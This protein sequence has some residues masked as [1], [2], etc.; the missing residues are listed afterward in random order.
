[1]NRC[2]YIIGGHETL[3]IW[4]TWVFYRSRLIGI[5]LGLGL[6]LALVMTLVVNRLLRQRLVR[7]W[8]SSQFETALLLVV[9]LFAIPSQIL[10]KVFASQAESNTSSCEP[11][12][13][14][15]PPPAVFNTF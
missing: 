6:A 4:C 5:V 9:L 3:S 12:A 1:M 8:I 15:E 10:R 14:L 13:V 2:D 11:R 7:C